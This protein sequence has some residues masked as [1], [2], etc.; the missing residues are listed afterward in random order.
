M[1]TAIERTNIIK[2]VTA[3]FNAAP[4]ATYLSELVTFFDASG[5]T[6][7]QKLSTQLDPSH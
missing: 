7:L 4:G 1:A 5:G 2:L 3:M 6:Q